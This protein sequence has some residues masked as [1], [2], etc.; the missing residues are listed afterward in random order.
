MFKTVTAETMRAIDSH[1]INEIGIPSLVLME[2]AA[3]GVCRAVLEAAATRGA[4][5]AILCG[6]GNNGGD[7]LA[8]LRQLAM[9][10]VSATAYI[11]GDA[12]HMS[13]DCKTQLNIALRLGLNCIFV[14]ESYDFHAFSD[15]DII[16]DAIFGTGLKREINGAARK[17]IDAANDSA[18]FKISI[19]IP[20][21]IDSDLGLIRGVAFRA[22]ETVAIQYKKRGHLLF[23]GREYSGN[24]RVAKIG[25][26]ASDIDERITERELEFPDIKALLPPRRQDTHKGCNGKAL[27]IAGSDDLTG[28]AIMST[29][30]AL[31]S[32]AGLLKVFT[33]AGAAAILRTCL[34]EAMTS[35]GTADCWTTF[36]KSQLE[37][38]I[39]WCDCIA[40]GPGI[41]HGHAVADMLS[42]VISCGKPLI[43]D[44]DGLNALARQDSSALH[45]NV[46]LTPHLGEMSRLC[47][48]PMESIKAEQLAHAA[49]YAKKTRANVL[50]KGATSIIVSPDGRVTYNTSGN[51]ALAKG[52]SG[53]MLTGIILALCG[54]IGDVY[55]SACAGSFI[56]GQSADTA[57][58]ILNERFIIAGDVTDAVQLFS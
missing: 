4:G 40:I 45:E 30:A 38:L 34:P 55:D 27:L 54:Q 37:S 58:D 1:M 2:N 24:V 52:G 47:A 48:K 12:S 57:L 13:D 18:A 50:L 3:G 44:A 25:L 6:I 29:R 8:L 26:S 53:D 17:A 42:L 20:S 22:D 41:G 19:D 31:R 11:V 33:A 36:D 15:F 21:G 16:V 51:P 49:A 56:L 5:T 35:V 28:A 9:N 46:L 39:D 14:D 23:P 43:I 32:G 7:G 10:G